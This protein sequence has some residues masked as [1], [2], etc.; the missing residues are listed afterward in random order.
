MKEFPEKRLE[1]KYT[2]TQRRVYRD[3][4]IVWMNWNG[5]SSMSGAVFNS[6]LLTRLLTSGEEDF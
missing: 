3:K 6:R 4:S 2:V 5:G 1:Q